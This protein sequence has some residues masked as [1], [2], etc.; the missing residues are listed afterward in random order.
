M[1]VLQHKLVVT[2]TQYIT[3]QSSV[4]A[5]GVHDVVIESPHHIES[6]LQIPFDDWVGVWTICQQRMK[7]LSTR[8]WYYMGDNLQ[9]R[10]RAGRSFTGTRPQPTDCD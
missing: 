5:Y 9:K 7:Q 10:W 8:F 2:Q 1:A 4:P 6:V 3:T